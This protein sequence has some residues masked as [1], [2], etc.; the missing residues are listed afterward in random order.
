[1]FK[2]IVS[3][4]VLLLLTGSGAFGGILQGQAWGVGTNN[5]IHLQQNQQ[6]GQSSQNVLINLSQN[7]TG[8]GFGL[9]SAHVF[10]VSNQIGL[11]GALGVSSLV[12]QAQ[13][14]S[15]GGIHTPLVINPIGSSS[16]L[17]LGGLSG[18]VPW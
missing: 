8:T 14:L 17:I 5:D 12:S 13:L 7:T 9:V 4:I 3:S 1:M 6:S 18:P 16:M 2:I 11:G 15:L 10:G